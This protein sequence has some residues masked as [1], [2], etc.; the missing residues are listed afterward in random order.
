MSALNL[1]QFKDILCL[2]IE[3][4]NKLK[5]QKSNA[6]CKDVQY[7]IQVEQ[8]VLLVGLIDAILNN[9]PQLI[10]TNYIMYKLVPI[11][12]VKYD[13]WTDQVRGFVPNHQER[14]L[15]REAMEKLGA[16]KAMCE[17]LAADKNT[18]PK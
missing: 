8:V 7:V 16:M 6:T 9:L 12:R 5:E 2:K 11:L 17:R 15:F 13:D 18:M 1:S 3:T 10:Y 4:M 14:P